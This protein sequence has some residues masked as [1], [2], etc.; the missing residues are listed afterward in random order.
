MKIA[1][2]S[3]K[4]SLKPIE[5]ILP[6]IAENFEMWEIVA[7]RFHYLPEIKYKLKEL[8]QSYNIDISI[9]APLSDINIGSIN[10][11]IRK[12][13]VREIA[14]SIESA[15]F[16]DVELVT[17]HPAH[18][19]PLGIDIPEVVRELNIESV[20]QL[21]KIGKDYGVELAIENMPKML[22]TTFYSPKDL[23][24]ALAETDVK[25]CFD[26][27]HAN[28]SKNINEF[29][30]YSKLFINVHLHD[31][32]GKSDPHLTLGKGNIDFKSVLKKLLKNYKGNLVIEANS[33]E[34]GFSS[35]WYLKKILSAINFNIN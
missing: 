8:L 34:S 18:L 3:P 12:Q 22:W 1:L 26:L 15:N 19:S 31:N 7:E 4:F 25:I 17:F 35:K 21:S 9:H 14:K 32:L 24:D 11:F 23:I 13:S 33:L 10:P 5:K 16:L 2:S 27:G 20:K 28:I 6:K 29:L 30:K